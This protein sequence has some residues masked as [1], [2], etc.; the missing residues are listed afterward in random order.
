MLPEDEFDWLLGYEFVDGNLIHPDDEECD[1][2]EPNEYET[3]PQ[4]GSIDRHGY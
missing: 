3:D 2:C 4:Y 1:G